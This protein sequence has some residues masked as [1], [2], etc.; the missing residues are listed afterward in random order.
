ML[1]D[2]EARKELEK[3]AKKYL[4]NDPDLQNLVNV[5]N[6]KSRPG[7]PVRGVLESIRVQKVGEY[8]AQEKELIE[9]LIYLFG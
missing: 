3:L 8:T 4:Q 9:D 1:S 6:D 7:L 2:D 5:I